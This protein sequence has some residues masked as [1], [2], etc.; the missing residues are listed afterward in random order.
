MTVHYWCGAE[1][2][3]TEDDFGTRTDPYQIGLYWG[4][5]IAQRLHDG[6]DEDW[7]AVDL[8]EADHL[9]V[10]VYGP[11]AY[12][13]RPA[14]ELY[15]DEE[16]KHYNCDGAC[17]VPSGDGVPQY[18]VRQ[19]GFGATYDSSNL[20]LVAEKPGTYYVRVASHDGQAGCLAYV[21]SVATAALPSYDRRLWDYQ[22]PGF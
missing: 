13:C 1:F 22:A 12:Y 9:S 19:V 11:Y 3:E 15:A 7:Y 16:Q 20:H 10:N 14:L 8:K 2:C 4:N 17:T 6:A 18:L 5:T 21:L